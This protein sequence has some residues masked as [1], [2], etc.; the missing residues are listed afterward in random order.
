[1]Y[2]DGNLVASQTTG[3]SWSPTWSE[4]NYNSFVLGKT[5]YFYLIPSSHL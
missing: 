4:S 2:K 1:M 5:F 3:E